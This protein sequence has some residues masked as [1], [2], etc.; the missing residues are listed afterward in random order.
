MTPQT[1]ERRIKREKFDIGIDMREAHTWVLN[2]QEEIARAKRASDYELAKELGIELVRSFQGRAIATQI[3]STNTGARSPG[4]STESFSTN[5]DYNRMIEDL[6]NYVDSPG[7]YKATP[8]DRIY[9]P[10]KDGSPR[11]LSIPSYTDRCLQALY[12]LALE[13][14]SEEMADLSSY[15]FRPIRGTSWA[16]G[17]TLNAIANPLTKYGYCVE[18]DIKGCFDNIDH[19]FL[20]EVTP[21]IPGHILN[22]WLTCGYME[23]GSDEL[24][25]TERGVPQ[26]GIL[27]PLLTNLV[28]D[29]L[30]DT[31]KTTIEQAKTGSKGGQFCRYADDMVIFTTTYANAQIALEAVKSFLIKRGLQIKEAKTRII[32]IYENSFQFLSYE[33]SL[34]YSQNRKRR[35]AC[36]SIPT[37]AVRNFKNKI[38]KAI[39]KRRLLTDIIP[40]LNA[41]IRGWA[42]YYRFSHKSVYVFRSLRYWCW[43]QYYKKCYKMTK[44][45]YD[46]ANHT[47]IHD[48]V[49]KT[50]FDKHENY[51]TWPVVQNSKGK[52]SALVDIT[53]ISYDAATYTNKAKNAYILEDREILDRVNLRL[54][55]RFLDDVLERWFGCCALCRK[56]LD[57][58]PI[59]YELHHILPKRFGGKDT[60]KNLAPLCKAPCHKLV[61]SAIA[62]KNVDEIQKYVG[63]GVLEVP[64][65]YLISIQTN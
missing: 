16:V 32:N 2:K 51:D 43:K 42:N 54:K 62:T 57:I 45:K 63:Y 29:G 59:P 7:T 22:E 8:L 46:K 28:L 14:I 30:E 10:K 61:S 26:G 27:S 12:K 47:F 41:I 9:I 1:L 11:P 5:E 48:Y 21:I 37:S 58:N 24:F 44:D 19:A 17:R 49:M 50:Y 4:L 60:P 23:R 13:P 38:K 18:I 25:P 33:F 6:L 15:G 56:R 52:P 64:A 39:G 3:V 35:V 65:D 55:K 53:S 20:R 31:I 36:I 40:E 34:I